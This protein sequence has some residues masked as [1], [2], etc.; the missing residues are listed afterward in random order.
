[1]EKEYIITV[2]TGPVMRLPVPGR[3]RLVKEREFLA[4][5]V[6][7]AYVDEVSSLPETDPG[8]DFYMLTE[9]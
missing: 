3:Q 4:G 5:I 6:G 2:Y 8:Y 9:Q 7:Q 1:M